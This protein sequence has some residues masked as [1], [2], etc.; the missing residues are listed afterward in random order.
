MSK[1]VNFSGWSYDKAEEVWATYEHD[2][3]GSKCQQSDFAFV[4]AFQPWDKT[5]Y[6][7]VALTSMHHLYNITLCQQCCSN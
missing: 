5:S 3:S 7:N 2:I 6:L 4:L 1:I